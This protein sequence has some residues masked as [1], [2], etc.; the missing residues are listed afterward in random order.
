MRAAPR[1]ARDRPA[2][3]GR[4][5]RRF[6]TT[7]QRMGRQCAR[8]GRHAHPGDP[9]AFE[10]AGVELIG[11]TPSAAARRPRRRLSPRAGRSAGEGPR[12]GRPEYA[13]AMVARAARPT[14]PS[15][16]RPKLVTTHRG[17][18]RRSQGRRDRRPHRRHRRLPLSMA[19]PSPRAFRRNSGLTP[20]SSAASWSPRSAAAP[21]QIGGPAGTFIVLV[22]ATV[23]Q[24]GIDGLIL[25]TFMSGSFFSPSAWCGSGPSSI[26]PLS[27]DRRLHGRHRRH[28]LRQPAARPCKP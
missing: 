20:P 24:F 8:R 13:E 16:S 10:R 28:H 14:S 12:R 7:I 27:G 11:R 1:P 25:A 15:C 26:H 18:R 2:S 21:A 4:T 19:S 9:E 23:H 6:A 22:A 17:R 5:C 3:A